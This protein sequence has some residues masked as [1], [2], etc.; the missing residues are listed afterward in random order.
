MIESL[1]E[2]STEARDQQIASRIRAFRNLLIIT[3][4]LRVTDKKDFME[5]VKDKCCFPPFNFDPEIKNKT[6]WKM[7]KPPR[8]SYYLY[9]ATMIY[10]RAV[11][12]LMET[13]GADPGDAV[14]VINRLRCRFHESIIGD[15]IWIH[16]NG[17]SEKNYV[18][19]SLKLDSDGQS[20]N[21]INV[22]IFNKTD[23]DVSV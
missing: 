1:D 15:R 2:L 4:E 18:V 8:G 11:M 21:L 3:Q 23:D 20:G 16:A 22:G 14:D 5:K 12:D 7:Y 6:G 9:D 10:G 17:Q 13:P 19:K